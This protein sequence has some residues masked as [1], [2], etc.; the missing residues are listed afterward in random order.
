MRF[1]SSKGHEVNEMLQKLI[2]KWKTVV[3][4][5]V[6]RMLRARDE[7]REVNWGLLPR[8]I[9]T[10]AFDCCEFTTGAGADLNRAGIPC[11]WQTGGFRFLGDDV[12]VYR[13]GTRHHWLALAVENE[14]LQVLDFT[15][16]YH[17]LAQY[18]IDFQTMQMVYDPLR[19]PRSARHSYILHEEHDWDHKRN[20]WGNQVQLSN[21]RELM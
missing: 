4:C 3:R 9:Q 20:D 16:G 13:G 2:D 19:E 10:S 1:K 7:R 15:I 14:H 12:F 6:E 8:L 11:S 18:R 21:P 17:L 5:K